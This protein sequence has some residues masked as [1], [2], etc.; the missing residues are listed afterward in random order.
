MP[1]PTGSPTFAITTGIGIALVAF[2]AARDDPVPDVTM[3]STLRRTNSAANSPR[4]CRC[5]FGEIEN[6]E[7]AYLA[8]EDIVIKGVPDASEV[9]QIER[10]KRIQQK[11]AAVRES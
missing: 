1:D 8:A 6:A 10:K 9:E 7:L 11:L 3:Q 5:P 2:L 4:R